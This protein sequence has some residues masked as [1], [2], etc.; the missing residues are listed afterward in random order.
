MNVPLEWA[1]G[2]VRLTVGR[3]TTA[4]QIDT[5][6]LVITRAVKKLQPAS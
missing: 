2:T 5:A 4:Q 3:E 6:G 1:M